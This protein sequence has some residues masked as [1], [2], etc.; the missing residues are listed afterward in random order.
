MTTDVPTSSGKKP[1]E[2][3]NVVET[4]Q[5]LVFAFAI[6][7]AVRSFVTEGFFIPTGS[8]APTL[9][10]QHVRPRSPATG[11]EY[12]ADAGPSFEMMRQLGQN[13]RDL[14]APVIDPMLSMTDPIAQTTT[15]EIARN[16]RMGDRVLV[17]K[18][19]YAF[20]D[21][22]RWDVVVFKNPTDPTG[23]A[24]NFIK[25]LVGLPEEQLLLLDGDV[26]TAPLG[27]DRS[28]FAIARKPEHVQRT[29]WIPV[30]DSDFVPVDPS[31]IAKVWGRP[32]P[33][34]PWESSEFD[35]GPKGNARVWTHGSAAPATISWRWDRRPITDFT[36]YNV[37]RQ[38][39][40]T[41][42]FAMS[43]I[44]VSMA[45]VAEDPAAL[46]IEETIVTRKRALRFMLDGAK[47]TLRVEDAS[48]GASDAAPRVLA[49]TSV[50]FEAPEAGAPYDVEFWHV[51]QQLSLW[52]NGE[53]VAALDY[54]FESLEDRLTASFNGRTVEDYR[55]NAPIQQPTPPVLSVRFAGSPVELHRVRVDRDL[56]YRPANLRDDDFN[57]PG[58]NG[59]PITGAAFA[60]D[61]DAPAQLQADQFMMLGDNSA[62]SRDSRL[63]GRPSPLVTKVFG[64]GDPFVVPRPLLLG[65]AWCVYFPAPVSPMQGWPAVLPDFGKLRF[66]R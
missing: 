62:A 23:D 20:S 33:G 36:S 37:W 34:L 60:T 28:K 7:M 45:V 58:E 64:E 46:A 56:Y 32:W 42:R 54:E 24:A 66:I 8:M 21:P 41:Q 22:Q 47:A 43:D 2:E 11:F 19:L 38:I 48:E 27:A 6:A 61:F 50:P 44:R 52:V 31:A 53:Q 49:E 12:A 17:L 3:T 65:K 39:P 30:H 1:K 55:R 18:Y 9:M 25:R 10:G 16:A 14:A 5:S 35:F 26:F 15:N 4:L 57:Q 29:V 13:Y 59:E 63:W 51:D 40:I